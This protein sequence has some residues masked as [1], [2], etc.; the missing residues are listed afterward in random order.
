MGHTYNRASCNFFLRIKACFDFGSSET[1]PTQRGPCFVVSCLTLLIQHHCFRSWILCFFNN[2]LN[3]T[4]V[5]Q[6]NRSF[7][8]CL[9]E[10]VFVEKDIVSNE[11]ATFPVYLHIVFVSFSVVYTKTMKTIENG[12]NQ[13]KSIVCMSR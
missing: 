9:Y 12:N 5:G 2:M 1:E 4:Y 10:Y 6:E 8:P 3:K 13:R 11:N 7:R